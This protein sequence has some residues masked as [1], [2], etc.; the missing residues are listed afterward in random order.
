MRIRAADRAR[1]R[2]A[3]RTD[4]FRWELE[5]PAFHTTHD[6]ADNQGDKVSATEH[7]ANAASTPKTGLF[8][9][10]AALLGS[11]ESGAPLG[12]GSC[13]RGALPSVFEE[14]MA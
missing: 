4:P 10:L 5:A 11:K 13:N 1:R 6:T 3:L 8:A 2:P 7:T 12:A 14:E 9:R